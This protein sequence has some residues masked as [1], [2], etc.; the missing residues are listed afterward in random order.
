MNPTKGS[1]V[2]V[3][4]ITN[5]Y[6]FATVQVAN[7]HKSRLTR[8]KTVKSG[9]MLETHTANPPLQNQASSAA[10][11]NRHVSSECEKAPF[12]SGAA[13]R[14]HETLHPSQALCHR[15]EFLH[16]TWLP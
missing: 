9:I 2:G 1:N 12:R 7:I 15:R 5:E 6:V 10:I 16:R 3:L 13:P 11:R 4:G 8:P 14:D